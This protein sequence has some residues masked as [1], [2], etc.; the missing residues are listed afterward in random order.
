MTIAH[1]SEVAGA[2]NTP[3]ASPSN[4]DT[5]ITPAAAPNGVVV[6]LHQNTSTADSV[7]SVTYGTGA[8]AVI[9]TRAASPY[10][11]ASEGTE[12]GAVYIYWAGGSNVFPSGAQTV[13]V[14]RS[15]TFRMQAVIATMTVAAGKVV[16]LDS[17]GTGQSASQA[18]PSWTHTSL[19]DNVMAYLG[20]HSGL[21][22]MTATPAANWTLQ[23]STDIGT[24]G[25]G[26]ARLSSAANAAGSRAPGWTAATADDFV[27]ASIA[28]FES[29]PFIV[30]AGAVTPVVAGRQLNPG[31]EASTLLNP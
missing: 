24:Q 18:N 22:A 3:A 15:G 7:S 12:A 13:R 10:G 19:V 28:F 30:V 14:A 29:D 1:Q 8:G 25:C 17:G 31:R 16:A 5:S 2:A 23:S 4:Y 20:I 21:N 9:L 27:G 6:V 26:F 11:F